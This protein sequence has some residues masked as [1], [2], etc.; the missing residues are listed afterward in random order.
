[1]NKPLSDQALQ[2]RIDQL[3]DE[4]SPERDLWPGIE[5]ALVQ[6]PQQKPQP[7]LSQQVFSQQTSGYESSAEAKG[8]K[9]KMPLAWAASVI[10][11]VLLTWMNLAPQQDQPGPLNLVAAM[12]QDF[13]LQKKTMLV[14]F[15]QPK[16]SELPPEMQNQ[17]NQLAAARA[18]IDK[19]LAEDPNNADLLSLLRW[20]QQQELD[21]IEQL[22]SPQWQSI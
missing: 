13:E 15:G 1:M 22:Y 21:L 3:P 10:A 5:R 16:I 18:S 4:M 17:L 19:A 8:N 20:T 2:A 12:Q 14:S 11:A 9:M 7:P 6:L